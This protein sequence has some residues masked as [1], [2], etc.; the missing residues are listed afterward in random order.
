MKEYLDKI[1]N[2]LRLRGFADNTI[3]SYVLHNKKF[4]EFINKKPLDVSE[5]D[6]KS[7][8]SSL[9]EKKLSAA[10]LALVRSALKFYYE[11]LL[12]RN[13]FRTIKTP[14]KQRK[15]PDVLTKEE[16]TKLVDSAKH[17]K[18]KLIISLLYSSGLRVS[19]ALNMK[20]QDIDLHEKVGYVRQGKGKKDRIFILSDKLALE[21]EDYLKNKKREEHLFPGKDGKMTSRNVQK[22]IRKTAK[23][24]GINKKVSP[25]TLRHSYGTH[26]LENGVDIRKIQILLGHSQLSTTQLYTQVSTEELKKIKSPFDD[27]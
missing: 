23:R 12:G 16:V 4:F 18:S 2:E 15:L 24:A 1:K 5:D 9:I 20:I 10:S 25:H 7:F 22:M 14:K 21:L 19:E 8:L 3:E 26:L 6:I 11:E 13:I 17:K 27:L